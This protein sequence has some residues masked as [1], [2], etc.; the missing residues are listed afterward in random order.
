MSRSPDVRDFVGESPETAVGAFLLFSMLVNNA[1]CG[2][3]LKF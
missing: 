3:T 2:P 1:N